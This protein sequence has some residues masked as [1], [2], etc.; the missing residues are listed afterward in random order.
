MFLYYIGHVYLRPYI[1][2]FCQIFQALHLLPALRLLQTLEYQIL[3]CAI[4][5]EPEPE[6]SSSSRAELG[7]FRAELGWGT[8]ISELK[9]SW[10]NNNPLFKYLV[11]YGKMYL[12][13]D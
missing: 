9:P 7:S 11:Y 12:H 1:Y 13:K 4:S 8:S 10:L 2:S 6:F 5:D 3:Y